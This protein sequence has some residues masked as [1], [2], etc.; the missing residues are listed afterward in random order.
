MKKAMKK[1]K[2]NDGDELCKNVNWN[3]PW[4]EGFAG[5][6][7]CIIISFLL[8]LWENMV[9]H[10]TLY[11][12]LRL[13]NIH[14]RMRIE[15]AKRW[16]KF[17]SA[18]RW[19]KGLIGFRITLY[20]HSDGYFKLHWNVQL[21]EQRDDNHQISIRFEKTVALIEK[22]NARCVLHS[23]KYLEVNCANKW[24][25]FQ[26]HFVRIKVKLTRKICKSRKIIVG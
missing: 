14:K 7:C 17:I 26:E 13:N 16:Q 23:I 24:V 18:S 3:I 1:R 11:A 20:Y 9:S 5:N 4:E 22:K 15:W 25:E 19:Q 2:M 8:N 10:H 21:V 12:C 6:F